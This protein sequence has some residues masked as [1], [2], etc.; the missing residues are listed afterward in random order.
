VDVAFV[1]PAVTDE[2]I[3]VD[4]LTWEQRIVVV[5]ARSELA[6]GAALRVADGASCPS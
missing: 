2:R 5:P 3:A 1:R 4:P 6:E